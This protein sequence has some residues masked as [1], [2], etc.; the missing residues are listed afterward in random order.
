MDIIF[1]D[2]LIH[3]LAHI[4]YTLF[5]EKP[6]EFRSYSRIN[7]HF[8]ITMCLFSISADVKT[9]IIQTRLSVKQH[10]FICIFL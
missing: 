7:H 10:Y 5:N 1:V 6:S 3:P 4:G 8:Y 2:G 9:K